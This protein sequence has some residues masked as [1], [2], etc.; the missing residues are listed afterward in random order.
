MTGVGL[1]CPECGHQVAAV[2]RLYRARRRRG[3]AAIGVMIL[4][5]SYALWVVPRVTAG[6]WVAAVPT[7]VLIAGMPW[8]PDRALFKETVRNPG[9][10][11]DWTLSGRRSHKRLWA[12]Q[13]HWLTARARRIVRSEPGVW[14]LWRA[15]WF[16]RR[17]L[18]GGELAPA[19]RRAAVRGLLSDAGETRERAAGWLTRSVLG[20]SGGLETDTRLVELVPGLIRALDDTSP[21]VRVAAATILGRLGGAAEPSIPAL[22]SMLGARPQHVRIAAWSAMSRL[23]GESPAA[24]GALLG[25]LEG[26]DAT[27]RDAAL[28]ALGSSDPADDKVTDRLLE[29]LAATND[30][31]SQRAARALAKR[32]TDVALAAPALFAQARLQRPS[33]GEYIACMYPYRGELGPFVPETLTFLDDDAAE[34][35]RSAL[36]LLATI[37]P[38]CDLSASLTRFRGLVNDPDEDS[39]GYAKFLVDTLDKKIR[40]R[41]PP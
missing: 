31:E 21:T 40:D 22:A 11:E 39:A 19:F 24:R 32:K 3:S 30:K 38:H 14:A 26:H 37:E 25:V 20:S 41:G 6:G 18:E 16:V 17:E 23:V 27:A 7:T 33:R 10:G 4:A 34:V 2:K 1:K 5:S 28:I 35:R 36:F 13:E 9:R 15:A 29:I 8:L 12:W